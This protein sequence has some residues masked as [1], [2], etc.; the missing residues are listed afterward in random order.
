MLYI[1]SNCVPLQR[2]FYGKRLVNE[3]D[4]EI[5]QCSLEV[6]EMY[7]SRQLCNTKN[8]DKNT[9]IAAVRRDLV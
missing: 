2:S 5:V 4:L 8:I 9:N 1:L 3:V 6:A 7:V